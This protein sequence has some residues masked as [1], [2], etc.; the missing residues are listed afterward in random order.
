M[1]TQR[2][3]LYSRAIST[4][5]MPAGAPTTCRISL[6]AQ[7]SRHTCTLGVTYDCYPGGRRMWVSHG[8]R[9]RFQCSG[10]ELDCGRSTAT[11][12]KGVGDGHYSCD[13][14]W[15]GKDTF[16]YPTTEATVG[17]LEAAARQ[18]TERHAKPEWLGAIISVDPAGH[19]YHAAT[20]AATAAGFV[21]Q[22]IQAAKPSDYNGKRAM[23]RSLLGNSSTKY[24]YMIS[25]TPFEIALLIGH[26]R[27]LRA[28]AA[29][30]YAW[31]AVFEDDIYLHEAVSPAYARHLLAAA[32]AAADAT[33]RL[34]KPLLYIG[35]C[36]PRCQYDF[37]YAP[38]QDATGMH[39]ALLRVGKCQA[40]C[41][42]A[43]AVSRHR[44]ASLFDNIFE[45]P[46][47]CDLYP[48]FMDWAMVRYFER[49]GDAWI[50]G[51]GLEGT[52]RRDH[53][54]LFLQNRSVVA[55][56]G[57]KVRRSGLAKSYTWAHKNLTNDSSVSLEEQGCEQS[58]RASAPLRKLRITIEWSGRLGNLMFEV[59][60]LAGVRARLKSIVNNTEITVFKLPSTAK[61]PAKEMFE[62]FGLD[63]LMERR[64][65]WGRTGYEMGATLGG[66]DACALSMKERWPNLH[67]QQMLKQ[68]AWWVTSPPRGCRLGFIKL[69][70]YFQ[71]HLYFSGAV[72]EQLRSMLFATP[73]A[74]RQEAEAILAAARR[75]LSKRGKLIGVQVR[76]GDKDRDGE[77]AAIYA[78]TT[79]D[80]YRTAMLELSALLRSRG[81]ADVAFIVTAGGSLGAND[82][83]VEHARGNLSLA[84]G[85]RIHFSTAQSP[86][87]DLAVLRGCDGLVIGPSTFGWWAAYLANLPVGLVVAPRRIYSQKLP[88]NHQL[89]VG[90]RER[91]YYPP[92]WRLLENDGNLANAHVTCTLVHQKSKRSPCV[93]GSSYDCEANGTRVQMWASHGCRGI[94]ACG[95]RADVRC[96]DWRSH[97]G[98]MHSSGESEKDLCE[99][100]PCVRSMSADLCEKST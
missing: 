22:H 13:C 95:G 21:V 60:M 15:D 81:A 7:Q 73:A 80:Y 9:G 42:H 16:A 76:L 100:G 1:P 94:F 27:A 23:V 48:C 96:G 3:E 82:V 10:T 78:D 70:G 46:A 86:F 97:S 30:Q 83:D 69:S 74:G 88:P 68:M 50:V 51:G 89:V 90:F 34:R 40:F 65:W 38:E 44:A 52:F 18:R 29:S 11:A 91:H 26:K 32:F 92:S 53:R 6:L 14:L 87:V 45:Q 17:I 36:A 63:R 57:E 99:C 39:E 64:E 62:A 79:W 85:H 66:C 8:C 58:R 37:A 84:I 41:T 77:Y 31:G 54:G 33:P 19:R 47:E 35:S 72:G 20:T 12:V 61:V 55:Q 25:M 49:S 59:A 24:S 4:Q 67:N 56:D 93:R 28:I 43:Y 2:S 98:F 5:R 75:D 71:S